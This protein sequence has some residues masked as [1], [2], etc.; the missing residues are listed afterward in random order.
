M[1]LLDKYQSCVKFLKDDKML[2]KERMNAIVKEINDIFEIIK[3]RQMKEGEV[4]ADAVDV[5]QDL[6]A[7]EHRIVMRKIVVIKAA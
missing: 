4:T 7:G 5:T 6:K 2:T 3:A 1:T